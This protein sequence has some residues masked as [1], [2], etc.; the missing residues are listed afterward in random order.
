MVK[1]EQKREGRRIIRILATDIDGEMGLE[2]ALRKI[3]GV[4]FAFS[5]AVCISTGIEHN[6]KISSLAPEEIAKIENFIKSPALPSWMLNRRRDLETGIDG[7]ITK[8]D[9]DF[10]RREDINS[11]KKMRS[12]KGVRHEMGQPVRGQRTRSTFRVN[13]TV[14]VMKRKQAPGK[15]AAKKG[16]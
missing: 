8:T 2:R 5:R 12:Y 14:G 7:H 11:L 13:K 9:I 15:S 6:K 1:P 3:K 10:R 16:A 4:S